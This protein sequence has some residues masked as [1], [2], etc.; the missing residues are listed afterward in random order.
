MENK[1]EKTIKDRVIDGLA[2]DKF[3]DSLETMKLT[4]D[5]LLGKKA[6]DEDRLRSIMK[7]K[8]RRAGSK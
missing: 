8:I 4:A 2:A 1:K 6:T 5:R 7:E 3:T